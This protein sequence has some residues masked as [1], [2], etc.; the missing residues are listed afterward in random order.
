MLDNWVKGDNTFLLPPPGQQE[1]V[2]FW[3]RSECKQD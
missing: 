2:L 3:T 1:I